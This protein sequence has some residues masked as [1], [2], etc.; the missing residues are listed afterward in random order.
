[1]SKS[2]E[3]FSQKQLKNIRK[4]LIKLINNKK[5]II[6]RISF[7]I[8]IFEELVYVFYNDKSNSVEQIKI[9]LKSKDNTIKLDF[10]QFKDIYTV[11]I[12]EQEK[13]DK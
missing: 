11:L 5:D 9:V 7:I 4:I 3:H 13:K 6:K 10:E 1:L 12:Y 8:L 2:K